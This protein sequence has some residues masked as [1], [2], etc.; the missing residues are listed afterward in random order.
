MENNQALKLGKG[1]PI[2]KFFKTKAIPL[3]VLLVII[4]VSSFAN[5]VFFTTENF[6]NLLVQVTTNMICALGMLC[7]ILTGGIDLSVGSIIA[8]CGVLVAGL[9]I[10]LNF[11]LAIL[12]SLLAGMALGCLN[13]VIISKLKLAPFIVT[14][15]TM[16]F[17]RG[18]A[19]WYTNATPIILSQYE[20]IQ[21]FDVFYQLGAGKLFNA[22]PISA[23]IWLAVCVITF[24]ILQFTKTG[25]IFYAIGGN[26][27]AVKLSGIRV[28]KYKIYAYAISGL[29]AALAGILLT[30]RLRV[31]TPL[32]GDGQEMD[33]IAAVVIGG[34]SLAG[35]SG[36]VS[37]TVIGVVVLAVITNILNLL[38]VSSYP[39]MMLRGVIIVGAVILSTR[40]RIGKKRAIKSAQ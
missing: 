16:S 23:I 12:I 17:A 6:V 20:E 7:V 40:D 1:N 29:F 5:R 8:V 24:F 13:G 35:G 36:T 34:G 2:A 30:S 18:L 10:T 4:V 21:N 15:G 9:S 27:E 31:G 14:L 19:Y 25:R 22:V 39:Q 26:E 33:S 32:S 37:G 38:N 3:I 28:D 11:W